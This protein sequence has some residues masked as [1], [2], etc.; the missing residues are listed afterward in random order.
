[1]TN[2]R[3]ATETSTDA[4][5]AP[6]SGRQLLA[7]PL[8]NKGTAFTQ[9]ERVELGMVGML[10]PQVS[11]LEEQ[12]ER[13][14]N[15]YQ[16]KQTD[17]ERH[18]YLRALQDRNETLFYALV[19]QHLVDMMP[20]IYTPTVGLAC[21]QFSQIYR[22][23]R[24]L[25]L[26]W[27]ERESM[28]QVLDNGACGRNIE[29]I[30][31]TDAE[32]I[33]GLGDQGAGGMGIPIGKLSL[34][35][36]CG[37]IDPA[38]TLP[39]TLD[40]GTDN[41]ERLADPLYIGWRHPRLR[42]AEYD[43]FIERFV[44]AVKQHFPNAIL[45]WE[46]FAQANAA[47]LLQR[48]QDS[49]CTFNDDIQG[50]AS[51]TLGALLSAARISGV[52]LVEQRVVIFGAGSA[53]CGI[54]A[55]LVGAMQQQGL[56]AE[57]ANAR[58]YLINRGGLLTDTSHEPTPA[59]QPFLKPSA[60]LADWGEDGEGHIGLEA[61][62][63]QV[64]PTVLIG[65]SG[66]GGAFSETV[67]RDMAA[68][69]ERP[70]VFPLSNPTSKVEVSPEWLLKW[71]DGRALVATGS[72]FADLEQDG[73]V[74]PVAQC[75]N[76]YIFPGIGLGVLAAGAKRIPDALFTRAA[77]ALAEF[78]KDDPGAVLPSLAQIREVSVHIANAVARQAVQLGLCEAA[79]DEELQRRI[80]QRL[81]EPKYRETHL[82]DSKS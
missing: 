23:F 55:Q 14:Y 28:D 74:R 65:V 24:G 48:Y 41:A 75:N 57:Q 25:F 18:I 50:T 36:V 71:S 64:H 35:T 1:M 46:D 49:L 3:H 58:V 79:T 16:H 9:Q 77:E 11:T 47:R 5:I 6:C 37:G 82:A 39:I 4:V 33:L 13:C 43:D 26:T 45:Q 7:N 17:L 60:S 62:V 73:R 67:I 2:N 53:G 29:V 78:P 66:Q 63:R 27:P 34:Y 10:P 19:E 30:V 76:A 21:Q 81:W 22:Q 54:A 38:T 15:A 12:L 59:Q 32:R 56:S 68:H 80:Q 61:V 42:G 69:V 40:V 44:Q 52:P 70:V 8:F 51:V 72:P 31:V 20:I